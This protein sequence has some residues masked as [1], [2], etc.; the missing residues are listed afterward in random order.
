M[1]QIISLILIAALVGLDRVS[2]IAVIHVFKGGESK[3][4]LFGLFRLRYTENTGAAFSAFSDSTAV[5]SVFTVLVLILCLF[6]LLTRKAKSRFISACLI[7]IIAGGTGNVIDR[8]A[9]G[10]VVD[11]IEPLFMNFAVFNVADI[12]VTVGAGLLII[13]EIRELILEK[14]KGKQEN[15]ETEDDGKDKLI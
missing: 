4:I 10:F 11:F 8:I 3:D 9:K 14:K 13:Y 7:L 5:L 12:F 15:K 2:K 1:F 6:V